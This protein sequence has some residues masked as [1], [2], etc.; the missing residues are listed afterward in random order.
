MLD[1][2]AICHSL[3]VGQFAI[4]HG[5][6]FER[7]GTDACRVTNLRAEHNLFRAPPRRN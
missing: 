2:D 5:Q 1:M 7:T 6:R 3:E 4:V